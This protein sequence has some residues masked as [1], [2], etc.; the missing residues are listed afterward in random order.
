MEPRNRG[1]K[2]DGRWAE[3]RALRLLRGQ[4]W[5]CVAQR[6]RCRYGEI[7]LLMVKGRSCRMRLLAVEVKARRR[8]G[9]DA[10][11]LAAFHH[12]KRLRLAR[13]LACWQADHPWMA[14]AG[15]EVVLALVPLAPS[16][17]PVRWVMVERLI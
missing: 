15:L 10:G 4:G 14:T 12:R 6:W 13:A 16:T 1:R 8:L 5:R 3:Q 7:D 17:R 2:L 11:G 9:P